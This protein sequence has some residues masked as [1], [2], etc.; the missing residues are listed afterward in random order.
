MDENTDIINEHIIRSGRLDAG[1]GHKL[2]WVDWGN[3]NITV[4]IFYLHGGPGEGFDEEDFAKFDP[5]RHRVVFHDQR[6][7]SRSTPF[8]SLENNTT[9]DLVTDI[10]KLREHL[11][12]DSVNLYGVSWGSTL[13]LLY[14][15]E[16]PEA[17]NKMLIGSVFLGRKS[18]SD[19]YLGGQAGV[20]FPEAWQ[21]FIENVPKEKRDDIGAY[22]YEKLRSNN[23]SERKHFAKEWMLYESSILRL[24]YVPAKLESG[25]KDFAAE[26]LAYLE[27][28]YIF[29]ACFIEDDFILKN[30]ARIRH[31]PTVIVHGRYDFICSPSA[32][33]ELKQALGD[34]TILHM[35]AAGHSTGETTQREVVKAYIN[36]FL[37]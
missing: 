31:I 15:I 29:N 22:Y 19:Y 7:S 5:A 16:K 9:Q 14:A 33:Y 35:T 11:E 23:E 18:D 21:R 10:T 30:A 36:T 17:I 2:Y 20:H 6:G 25:L 13:A 26:S 28:H 1:D 4:P 12:F 37:V 34:N 24:D 27:A 8:A 3:E 32:A